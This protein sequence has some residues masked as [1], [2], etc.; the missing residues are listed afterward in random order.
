MS[1]CYARFLLSYQEAEVGAS[2]D[3]EGTGL[4]A[5]GVS[6][7]KPTWPH[8]LSSLPY[9]PRRGWKKEAMDRRGEEMGEEGAGGSQRGLG[10]TVW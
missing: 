8:G 7:H 3:P 5:A 9:T 10:R 6:D 2:W 4:W 1:P